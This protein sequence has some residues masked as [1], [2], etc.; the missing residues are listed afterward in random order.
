MKDSL[1]EYPADSR[2]WL[3]YSY[4]SCEEMRR[5]CTDCNMFFRY[6][7]LTTASSASRSNYL[8]I[9]IVSYY[10]H[11]N[12]TLNPLPLPILW[13]PEEPSQKLNWLSYI[14]YTSIYL[15]YCN[16]HQI[17]KLVTPQILGH[18]TWYTIL[19]RIMDEPQ[20]QHTTRYTSVQIF[21]YKDIWLGYRSPSWYF[22]TQVFLWCDLLTKGY[23]F[24]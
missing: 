23:I 20:A 12:P 24:L 9:S 8:R 14:T 22:T 19:N 15:K 13:F 16:P 2:P 4:T 1:S 21:D 3:W 18:F 7:S 10:N 17:V 5:M 6:I 11:R